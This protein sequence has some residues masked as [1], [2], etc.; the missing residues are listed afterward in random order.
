MKIFG[1]EPALVLGFVGAALTWAVSLGLD[2]LNAGQATAIITFLT[3]AVIAATTRPWAPGLFVGAFA[4]LGALFAEYGLHLSDAFV[5][6]VGGMILA[7]FALVGVR[8]Q[9]T[10]AA[11]PRVIDGVVITGPTTAGPLR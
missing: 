6:G 9:A 4:A 7:A 2:W 8:P 5:T 1:R 10:P 11:D 3:G